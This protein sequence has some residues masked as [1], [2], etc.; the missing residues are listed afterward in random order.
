MVF[1]SS[2]K[3]VL[4]QY[5]CVQYVNRIHGSPHVSQSASIL[6]DSVRGGVKA[7]IDIH[8]HVWLK[9]WSTESV[10]RVATRVINIGPD[11]QETKLSISHRDLTW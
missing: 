5:T 11:P 6:P 9:C 2:L 8:V 7:T 1:T 10:L 3:H 4:P